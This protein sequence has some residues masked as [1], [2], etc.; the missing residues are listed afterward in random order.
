M[1]RLSVVVMAVLVLTLFYVNS[2]SAAALSGSIAGT[3]LSYSDL[4]F[5]SNA[6]S[7]RIRNNGP[8]VYFSS[9]LQVTVGGEVIMLST[10]RLEGAIPASGTAVLS[11]TFPSVRRQL[12]F[13]EIGKVEWLGMRITPD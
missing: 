3:S 12:R 4:T 10:G 7:A 2:A 13:G 8:A 11:D 6:V 9:R 5:S 1:K